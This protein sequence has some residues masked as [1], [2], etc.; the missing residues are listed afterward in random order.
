MV[1]IETSNPTPVCL[2]RLYSRFIRNQKRPL[3][4]N[5]CG[6]FKMKT[7]PTHS[8][9]LKPFATA[10][11]T[12]LFLI[13]LTP[14]THAASHAAPGAPQ[15]A[16]PAGAA[17]AAPT[18]SAN[19][20]AAPA[21]SKAEAEVR[22]VDSATGRIQLRHGPIPSLDMPPMTMVFRVKSPALLEGLKEGDKI[23]FTA[24]KIDGAYTVTSVEKRP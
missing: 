11:A 23:F 4:I 20:T 2:I 15:G 3:P 8:Q 24:E 6:A 9:G 7:I 1:T 18:P 17:P 10:V 21:S 13:T 16:A 22:R 19:A 5:H 12:A 14:N